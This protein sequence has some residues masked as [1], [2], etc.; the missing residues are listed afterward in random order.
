[1]NTTIQICCKKLGLVD[2]F[3]MLFIECLFNNRTLKQEILSITSSIEM[4]VDNPE[5]EIF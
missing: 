1:M 3:G 5:I 4:D 2:I